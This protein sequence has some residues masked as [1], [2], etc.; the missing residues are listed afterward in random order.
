MCETGERL[1]SGLQGPPGPGWTG[2]FRHFPPSWRPGPLTCLL[3]V[4]AFPPAGPA[5]PTLRV[6]PSPDSPQLCHG[7]CLCAA[8]HMG[9]PLLP[10]APWLWDGVGA[11]TSVLLLP[12]PLLSPSNLK[13][14]EL[15]PRSL[16]FLCS[17]KGSRLPDA[18]PNKHQ[19]AGQCSRQ[20]GSVVLA[21]ALIS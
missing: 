5:T 1:A 16:G 14:Q 17:Q 20:R 18:L 4:G 6:L 15:L 19:H 7:R 21:E 9:L 8:W 10:L 2:G 12:S 3:T 13:C 11:L